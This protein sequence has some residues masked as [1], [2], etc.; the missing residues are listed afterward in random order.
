MTTIVH[1]PSRAVPRRTPT[2]VVGAVA[3]AWIAAL[4][5]WAT[6]AATRVNHDGLIHSGLPLWAAGLIFLF[7]WQVMIAAMMLPSS[8]PLIRL[9]VTVSA[10]APRARASLA[11]FLAGYA[12]VWGAFGL[13]AFLADT[14]LHRFV[15]GHPWLAARPQLIV[16]STLLVAGLFQFSKLKDACLQQCRNPGAYLMPRYR[17]GPAAGFGLGRGHGLFCLGCCWALMLLMFAVGMTSLLWM[18]AA[19][20]LMF[21]E[22]VGAHGR[23]VADIAGVALLAAGGITLA[24]PVLT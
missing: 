23:R 7:S 15:D 17:R 6:G 5:S 12:A 4:V 2:V 9:Y 18:A 22:K 10:A 16:G 19:G 13:G 3:V 1:D 14:R 8:V 24:V 11:A 21:Y 20:A